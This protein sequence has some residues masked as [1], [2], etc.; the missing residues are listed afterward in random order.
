MATN[1]KLSSWSIRVFKLLR[2]FR[3]KARQGLLRLQLGSS[4]IPPDLAVADGVSVNATDGGRIVFGAHCSVDR[5]ATLIA[6]FG[7]ISM[8]EGGHVGIGTVI[9]ARESIQIGA[10]ALIAEYVTIRDQ[11]HLFDGSGIT[12]QSGFSTAPI[13]IGNNVWLGAKVTVTKG[14][15]IGDNVVVGANS[16]VTRDI[17]ANCVA[18]GAPARVIRNLKPSVPEQGDHE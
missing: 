10:N 6:K 9:V 4:D 15:T 1:L 7:S 17:P 3:G 8:G 11:D 12:S 5:N 14:V 18:A 13:V 2:S 16:V